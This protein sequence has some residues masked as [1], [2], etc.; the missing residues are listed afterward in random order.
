MTPSHRHCRQR[1]WTA[2]IPACN[3]KRLSFDKKSA[4]SGFALMQA[5]M[6]AVQSWLHSHVG[7]RFVRP[8]KTTRPPINVN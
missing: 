8:S 5:G 6:P 2:G 1:H 3:V 4:F 7:R